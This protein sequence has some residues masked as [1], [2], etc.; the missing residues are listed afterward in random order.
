MMAKN[1][2]IDGVTQ[3]LSFGEIMSLKAAHIEDI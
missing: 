1:E 3:T 2:A